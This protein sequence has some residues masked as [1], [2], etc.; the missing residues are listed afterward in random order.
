MV[1]RPSLGVLV[2]YAESLVGFFLTYFTAELRRFFHFFFF[3][4]LKAA[5]IQ[6][7]AVP[8]DTM[9]P[10]PPGSEVLGGMWGLNSGEL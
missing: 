10:F 4:L 5:P 3:S 6:K 9:P 8:G 7:G 2:L 1:L